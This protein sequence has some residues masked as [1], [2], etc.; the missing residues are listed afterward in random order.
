[1][2]TYALDMLAQ[3]IKSFE[4]IDGSFAY[5]GRSDRDKISVLRLV[6]VPERSRGIIEKRVAANL[7]CLLTLANG[8]NVSLIGQQLCDMPDL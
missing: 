6:G 4:L 2:L 5:L 1:M 8:R 7:H 3:C